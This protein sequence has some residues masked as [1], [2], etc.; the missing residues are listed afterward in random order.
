MPAYYA[1][2]IQTFLETS[3][4]ELE[5]KLIK[6]YETDRFRE[7]IIA[8][9]G[10]WRDEIEA[11]KSAFN[12]EELA[13]QDTSQWGIA[14]EFVVPRRM[15]RIDT[16]LLIRDAIVALEFKTQ[17]D[18]STAADQVEDYCLDLLDFH[19]PSHGRVLYPV[20]VGVTKGPSGER[21]TSVFRQLRHTRFVRIAEL[22]H[23]LSGIALKH[24]SGIQ[25]PIQGW[26]EGEYHPVPTIVEAAMGMFAEMEVEDI[27]KADCDPINLSA[28]VSTIRE[29][30]VASKRAKRKTVCL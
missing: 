7:L 17:V 11:L 14:L 6:A 20:V 21:K 25:I 5:Y 9:I 2:D 28:T 13:R 27:A 29:L 18:T 26:N 15:G 12:S 8:Q 3:S 23:F 16:V 19:Q 30:A 4:D 24:G 22:A 1:E 10:A